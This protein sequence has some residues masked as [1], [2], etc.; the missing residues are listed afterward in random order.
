MPE[1][2]FNFSPADLRIPGSDYKGVRSFA[3]A[4]Q[5]YRDFQLFHLVPDTGDK[6]PED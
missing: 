3:D 2:K 1:D 5:A 4:G 6:L